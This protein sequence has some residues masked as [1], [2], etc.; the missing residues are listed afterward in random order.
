[1]NVDYTRE[2][3]TKA[4]REKRI[5][6]FCWRDYPTG[7]IDCIPVHVGRQIITVCEIDDHL[8][9]NRTIS[10]LPEDVESVSPVHGYRDFM[11][12]ALKRNGQQL[13]SWYPSG[14]T[15]GEV[16]E[17]I[18]PMSLPVRLYGSDGKRCFG[19]LLGRAG[20][21]IEM[22]EIDFAGRYI[23]PVTHEL[24][25]IVRVDSGGVYETCLLE[26]AESRKT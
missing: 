10:F 18:L 11:T 22:I 8:E 25:T 14:E 2:V 1:M 19:R 17:A 26:H 20:R 9:L 6:R 12:W 24:N 3:F 23:Y 15:L 16:I 5:T 7:E 4:A 13:A 21:A